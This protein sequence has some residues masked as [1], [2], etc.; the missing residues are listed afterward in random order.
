V[1]IAL[2]LGLASLGGV[3]HFRLAPRLPGA[4]SLLTPFRRTSGAELLVAAAVLAATGVLTG[5]APA[6]FATAAARAAASHQIV[7][8]GADYATTVRVRLTVEPGTV[9]SN[10]YI[11]QVDD[12]SS[13]K[14]FAGARG[15]QLQVSLPSHPAIG[16]STVTLAKQ[17]DDTW[18]GS[19]LQ[20]SI[21]GRWTVDAVVQEANTAVVIP[22]SVDVSL[23]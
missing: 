4:E 18:T 3:N 19:G 17:P 16:P 7:V 11:V 8:S 2:F 23:P 14:P 6:N 9:G 10:R 20:L 13:G 5:L 15:V 1:K 22:L 12:Y 21:A